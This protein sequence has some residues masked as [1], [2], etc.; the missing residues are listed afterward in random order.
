MRVA[1]DEKEK[2]AKE[3]S[4]LSVALKASKKTFEGS[5]ESFKKETHLYRVELEKLNQFKLERD[6]E[7]KASRKAENKKRQKDKK[8]ANTAGNDLD[9]KTE[10]PVHENDGESTEQKLLEPLKTDLKSEES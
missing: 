5:L 10:F 4:S 9:V 7:L 8:K 1:K 6:A 2:S 3:N